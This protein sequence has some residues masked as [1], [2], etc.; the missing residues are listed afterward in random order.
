[1]E[2]AACIANIG[3]AQRRRR[4]WPGALSLAAGIGLT[5]AVRALALTP[6]TYAPA[7]LLVFG[8]FTGILQARAKT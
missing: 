6:L 3:A 8:G 4:F 1:M 5:V 2:G 7:A